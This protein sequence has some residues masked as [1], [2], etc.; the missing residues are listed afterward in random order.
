ME[1]IPFWKIL[2]SICSFSILYNLRE[3]IA[4]PVHDME[5]K[6][7]SLH[8]I[9]AAVNVTIHFIFTMIIPYTSLIF[10]NFKVYQKL[11]QKMKFLSCGTMD[12]NLKRSL[13]K[14]KFSKYLVYSF[15][16]CH[17]FKAI[18]VQGFYGLYAVSTKIRMILPENNC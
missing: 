12:K 11:K 14:A 15:I 4:E 17:S 3:F 9:Y 18:G 1:K 16:F 13:F 5:N 8:P 2:L 7:L 6:P 10:T